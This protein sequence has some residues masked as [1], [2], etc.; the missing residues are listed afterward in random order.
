MKDF[1]ISGIEPSGSAT[2]MLVRTES[3]ERLN[4]SF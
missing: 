4:L 3:Q 2:V 1:A